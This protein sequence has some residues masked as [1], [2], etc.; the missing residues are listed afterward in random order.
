MQE[1]EPWFFS[2]CHWIITCCTLPPSGARKQWSAAVPSNA[3]PPAAGS[4]LSICPS[5]LSGTP[6]PRTAVETHT[7]P[8]STVSSTQ[9]TQGSAQHWR[10]GYQCDPMGPPC[11]ADA[12]WGHFFLQ[13]WAMFR[14][15]V[16]LEQAGDSVHKQGLMMPLSLRS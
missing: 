6:V 16:A 7:C 4:E 12:P 8:N 3:A 11:R 9:T 10:R 5:Q 13:L 15:R 1:E 14:S 2:I